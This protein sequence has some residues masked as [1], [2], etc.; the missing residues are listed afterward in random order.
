MLQSATPITS[1]PLPLHN[2]LGSVSEYTSEKLGVNG[3]T[4]QCI[5]HLSMVFQLQLV[6]GWE[7]V[8][9]K[10][11]PSDGPMRLGKDFTFY[12]LTN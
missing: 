5:S 9:K 2:S 8:K 4:T 7:L 12:Q 10:S 11:S 3:H 6:S 1:S